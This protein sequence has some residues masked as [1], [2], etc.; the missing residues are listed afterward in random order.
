MLQPLYL[1]DINFGI[2]CQVNPIH[3]YHVY[4][5]SLHTSSKEGGFPVFCG[6]QSRSM[7]FIFLSSFCMILFLYSTP[8]ISPLFL[9]F[10]NV[11]FIW[12]TYVQK[13]YNL[14]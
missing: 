2:K 3:L 4:V 7:T 8:I 6:L 11:I 13:A 12:R 14:P 9:P 1:I 10:E 5:V